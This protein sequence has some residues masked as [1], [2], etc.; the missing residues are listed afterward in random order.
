MH[1][2]FTT[3]QQKQL[4]CVINAEMLNK[5]ST[6]CIAD[7]YFQ[8]LNNY[9]LTRR[10]F[11]SILSSDRCPFY[12]IRVLLKPFGRRGALLSR[13]KNSGM[14]GAVISQAGQL[15]LCFCLALTFTLMGL[16]SDSEQASARTPIL[17]WQLR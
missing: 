2:S 12:P 10:I 14:S 8:R 1:C 11:F 15:G 13:I 4:C 16:K 17:Q 6:E 7:V 9:F 5:D 3:R